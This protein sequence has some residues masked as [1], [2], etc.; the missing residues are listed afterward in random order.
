MVKILQSIKEMNTPVLLHVHT[1]KS[2]RINKENKDA[3]KYYS[4]SGENVKKPS[5]KI[6]YS[7][8]LGESLYDLS[9]KYNFHCITAAMNIGTGL[10]KFTDNYPNKSI[11][12]G[13]AEEHA[14]T[15]A[16]GLSS[17]GIIPI[18][19]IYSTFMQRAYD[20]IIHDIALQ[21]LPA[22]FCMDR[23]GL[24]GNDGP[25][26]HGVFDIG[27][28]R[29]VPGLI[30]T[31]PKDGGEMYSLIKLGVK[32]KL[33]LSIRYPKSDTD[34]DIPSI[35]HEI[36]LGTWEILNNGNKVC[37]LTFGSMISNALE[38]SRI[39]KNRYNEDIVTVVNCRFIKPLD[40]KLLND[41]IENHKYFITIE[42]GIISGGFGSSISEYFTQNNINK[43]IKI[44]GINDE[45]TT[46][47]D[48]NTLLKLSG[49]DVENI[50]KTITELIHE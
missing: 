26:H 48:R 22:I 29:S 14:V 23:A 45:F 7:K 49:L 43:M 35:N 40:E 50:D 11:D 6:S 34:L 10:Q 39:F 21:N 13:I 2:K 32:N 36:K 20:C 9:S 15:Y 24:V 28:M 37:I 8:V 44:I 31:A 1:N 16:A 4:L 38:I 5:N 41:I 42:E 17:A 27:F 33:M 19:A 25:T 18:I 47:G 12:V 3:I 46:H 30:V